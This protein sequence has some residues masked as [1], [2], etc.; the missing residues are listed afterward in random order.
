VVFN[1]SSWAQTRQPLTEW[2][3]SELATK[4][5]VPR[6]LAM[7][8]IETDQ[9]LPLLDGLDEVATSLRGAC[10]EAINTYRRA[11]GLLPTVVCCRQTDYLALPTC[12]LLLTA[13]I[14]QPLTVQQVE[15]YLA[16]GGERLEALHQALQE[17]ADLQ[18]LATTPLMLNVL[19]VAYQGMPSEEI[20][21][22]G[23][24]G[25]KREQIFA[26]YV[27]RMLARRS[28]SVRYT[29][30]QTIHWLSWLAWQM[31]RHNQKEFYIERMQ[32]DWLP[33]GR[34]YLVAFSGALVV[35]IGLTFVLLFGIENEINFLFFGSAYG[36]SVRSV[37]IAL[38]GLLRKSCIG[39]HCSQRNVR[40]TRLFSLI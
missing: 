27:Q 10:V 15:S 35:V 3:A 40:L 14:V 11:H 31:K 37:K 8:W 26:T 25:S 33:H 6:A 34:G 38:R 16:N 18:A 36:L 39:G 12:L 1:L 4:Y 28:I 29:P 21:T 24:P 2:L 20:V 19:T 22:T 9:V 30:T 17:D 32:P 7:S 13:V 23:S 5:Q